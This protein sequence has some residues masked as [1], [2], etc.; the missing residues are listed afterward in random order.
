MEIWKFTLPIGAAFDIEMPEG[1][2]ILSLQAQHDEPQIWAHV[3][4]YAP[5]TKRRFL[6]VGT[7]QPI[8]IDPKCEFV[9]TFQIGSAPLVFHVFEDLT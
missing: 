3:D 1:A 6:M 8:A 7:G 5:L 4:V 2:K 9:G